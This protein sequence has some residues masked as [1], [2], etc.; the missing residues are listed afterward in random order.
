MSS[1][2]CRWAI[3]GI[4]KIPFLFEKDLFAVLP[5]TEGLCHCCW[6]MASFL[7]LLS[8]VRTSRKILLLHIWRTFLENGETGEAR[9]APLQRNGKR[10]VPPRNADKFLITNDFGGKASGNRAKFFL[11]YFFFAWN[12]KD[13][14]FLHF[15]KW[16]DVGNFYFCKFLFCVEKKV[17]VQRAKSAKIDSDSV[18]V[19]NVYKLHNYV[20][21]T[22]RHIRQLSWASQ[23]NVQNFSRP[24]HFSDWLTCLSYVASRVFI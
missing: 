17:T 5:Q 14:P 24:K 18:C 10:K 2:M 4:L 7:L 1:A 8:M 23:S 15:L 19:T 21:L 3:T 12:H 22:L 13:F 11:F 16:N 6:S 20:G 9:V